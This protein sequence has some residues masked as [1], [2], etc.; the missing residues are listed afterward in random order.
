MRIV[1]NVI[2]FSFAL[3]GVGKAGDLAIDA[4]V[5]RVSNTSSNLQIFSVKVTGGSLNACQN[6]WISF[7]ASATDVESQKRAYASALLALTT[8]LR[9]RVYNYEDNSCDSASYIEIRN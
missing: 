7:P 5:T 3:I 4:S 6:V 8:G 1:I 9:V 2:V